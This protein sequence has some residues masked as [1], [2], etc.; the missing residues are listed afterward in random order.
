[1]LNGFGQFRT[2]IDGLGIHFLHVRSPHTCALPL[3]ITHGWPGSITEFH[4]VVGAL[5]AP[6]Q[7][8]GSAD[9]AFH[10]VL[11]SLPGYGFSDKPVRSGWGI[12]RISQAWA[13]LMQRLG[14]Q[15][16]VAQGGD[17]GAVVTAALAASQPRGLVGI[18]LNVAIT[19]PHELPS[20]PD[21]EER[22]T[23][24]RMKEIE[25]WEMGYCLQQTTRPQT[26]GYGLADSPVGHAMWIY[27]KF[28]AWT[29][30]DGNVENVLNLDEILDNIM[31]YWWSNTGA[32]SA[33]LYWESYRAGMQSPHIHL[34]VGVTLFPKELLKVP[35]KWA[36]SYYHN[37]VYWN[38]AEKGGHFPALEQPES[39]LSEVRKCFRLMR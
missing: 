18:H 11:P 23:L 3:L 10:V 39:F 19:V 16:Y 9:D 38:I 20:A 14:Y 1:M 26:L 2:E 36:E 24:A 27:E 30:C 6:D 33:R 4:K 25:L 5:V 12:E 37:L 35:R 22:T 28:Q 15:R 29:D 34:P 8:G 31:I 7:Y 17:W 32:S 21:V 13:V